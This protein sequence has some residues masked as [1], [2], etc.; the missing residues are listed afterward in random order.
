MDNNNLNM[1]NN[2]FGNQNNNINNQ[3]MTNQNTNNNITN[4]PKKNNK[5]ILLIILLS[6][7]V[8]AIILVIYFVFFGNNKQDN[9]VNNDTNVN[10]NNQ[11]NN[12]TENELPNDYKI[13]LED[14]MNHPVS[15]ESDFEITDFGEGI[16]MLNDYLGDDD[17]VVIPETV[18]GKKITRIGKFAFSNDRSNIRAIK[19]SDSVRIL[20]EHAFGLNKKIEILVAGSGLEE[21]GIGAFQLCE[22]L[23]T[24]VL[25]E[26]LLKLEGGSFSNCDKLL[27]IE[28]PESVTYISPG[29][30]YGQPDDFTIIG[31][32]G[33]VAEE[34]AK[35]SD[36][37][38]QVK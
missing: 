8:L 4:E 7:I 21:I 31:A 16:V 10:E 15:P 20:E 2:G 11:G 5:L 23:N 34:H 38:F 27:S 18:D 37:K 6:V 36:I 1:G 24:V 30:F 28:V 19:L 12:D 29:A 13:T 3:Y 9:N 33:S 26:G 17:I 35:L 14:V 32:S 25:N 22:N